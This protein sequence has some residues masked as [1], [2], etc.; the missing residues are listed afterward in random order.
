MLQ[1]R[2]GQF[3]EISPDTLLLAVETIVAAEGELKSMRSKLAALERREQQAIEYLA[4]R[5]QWEEDV[6]GFLEARAQELR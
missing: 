4:S 5:L 1:A 6:R 3:P 2:Q